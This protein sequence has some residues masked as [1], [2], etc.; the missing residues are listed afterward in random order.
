MGSLVVLARRHGWREALGRAGRSPLM[1][2]LV[3]AAWGVVALTTSGNKGTGFITPL[4]PA[5]AVLTAWAVWRVPRPV[6]R[7][8]AGAAVA[9]LVL[10]S[11]VAFDPRTSWAQ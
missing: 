10:N 1:P 5:F 2:S 9:A 4:V 11:V 6:A 8:L 3:W 7:V